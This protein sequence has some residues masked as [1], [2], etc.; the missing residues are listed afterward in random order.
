MGLD[1][2]H[3][4]I[5]LETLG[6]DRDAAILSIGAVVFTE[7]GTIVSEFYRVLSLEDQQ[8]IRS[9]DI[10]TLKWWMQ[11]SDEARGVFNADS[12]RVTPAIMDMQEWM[13]GFDIDLYW[14]NDPEFDLGKLEHIAAQAKIPPMPWKFYQKRDF[15]TIRMALPDAAPREGVYHN[16][17]DD[18]IY[19]ARE[20]ARALRSFNRD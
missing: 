13:Q 20:C 15:R 17:L 8:E 5:D 6:L 3:C 4:M 7:N 12:E 19:Q 16:A 14:G 10:S 1:K 2:M 11:Q 9:V 18:A